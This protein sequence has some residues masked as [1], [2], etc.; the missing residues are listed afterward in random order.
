MNNQQHLPQILYFFEGHL[1]PF[2]ARASLSELIAM[3]NSKLYSP[4]TF[5]YNKDARQ[6]F[7][8]HLSAIEQCIVILMFADVDPSF[9]IER[10]ENKETYQTRK[11]SYNE[12]LKKTQRIWRDNNTS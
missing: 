2:L 8:K 10:L 9:Y 6:T 5:N 4:T 1:Y 7:Y 11:L 12:F 3:R